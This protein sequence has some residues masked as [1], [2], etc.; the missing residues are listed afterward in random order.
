MILPGADNEAAVHNSKVPGIW[1]PQY[2]KEILVK[3]HFFNK[4]TEKQKQLCTKAANEFGKFLQ[5]EVKLS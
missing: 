1:K 2:K 3:Q 5:K 4:P